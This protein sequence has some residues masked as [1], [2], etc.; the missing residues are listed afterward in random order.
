MP[1]TAYSC[2]NIKRFNVA[3]GGLMNGN[4]YANIEVEYEGDSDYWFEN[5]KKVYYIEYGKNY[6]KEL[7]GDDI[8]WTDNPDEFKVLKDGKYIDEDEEE[9]EEEE[10][11]FCWDIVVQDPYNKSLNIHDKVFYKLE[12]AEEYCNYF[13]LDKS[14]I[15]K[16]EKSEDGEFNFDYG[17]DD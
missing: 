1:F 9:E 2:E 11:E 12:D 6:K 15:R 4:A 7:I 16:F 14:I 13:K 5:I 10:N 3:G 17:V 8:E